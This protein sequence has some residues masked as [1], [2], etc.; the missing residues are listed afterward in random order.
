MADTLLVSVIHGWSESV[1]K[2]LQTAPRFYFFDTGVLNAING[3]L[4]FETKPES[5]RYGKLFETYI[6]NEIQRAAYYSGK[7]LR[8]HYWRTN[9]GKEVDLIISNSRRQPL[10]AIEIKSSSEIASEDLSGLHLFHEEY[11]NAA[12]LC[13][14]KTP[15]ATNL[16]NVR[17][18]PWRE[19]LGHLFD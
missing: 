12:L 1:K 6:I 3:E 2:Q 18:L 9:H 10:F 15:I 14:C 11:P 19:A 16:E 7:D 13:I 17:I 4:D 8:F 5:F